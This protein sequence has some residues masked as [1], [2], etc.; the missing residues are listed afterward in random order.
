MSTNNKEF[1]YKIGVSKNNTPILL[2]INS[3]VDYQEYLLSFFQGLFETTNINYQMYFQ[4]ANTM[5]FDANNLKKSDI[6]IIFNHINISP[7]EKNLYKVCIIEN[8]EC[9]SPLLSNALLKTIEEPKKFTYLIF[10]TNNVANVLETIKSRCNIVNICTNKIVQIEHDYLNKLNNEQ[11]QSL[12]SSF[13]NINSLKTWLDEETSLNVIDMFI[14]L[15]KNFNNEIELLKLNNTFV[16][17]EY[18]Q[19]K[20]ILNWLLNYYHQKNP[21]YFQLILENFD[22]NVSKYYIFYCIVEFLTN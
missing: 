9:L 10:T 3:N 16:K 17:L 4:T 6:D 14:E 12:I 19:I 1:L 15:V 5:I 2:T 7:W 21:T 11:K 13:K 18:K 20:I 22:V 8:I